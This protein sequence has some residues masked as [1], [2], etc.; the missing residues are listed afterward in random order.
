MKV[1]GGCFCQSVRYEA[2]VIQRLWPFATVLIVRPIRAAT[3]WWLEFLKKS[4]I[5]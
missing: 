3:V 2:V 1:E 5:C 4:F